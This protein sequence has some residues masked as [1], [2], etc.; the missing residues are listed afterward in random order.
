MVYNTTQHP[1]P[2]QSYTLSVYTVCLLWE[3][4][5]DVR[6]KVEG[7]AHKYS[8]FVHGG[9]SS[10]AGSKIPTMSESIPVY[11]ICKNMIQLM[12]ILYVIYDPAKNNFLS[13]KIK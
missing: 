10:Q 4:G 12:T 2:P 6:E 13:E 8:S 1:P 3:G 5:G 9:N 7:K 11:K